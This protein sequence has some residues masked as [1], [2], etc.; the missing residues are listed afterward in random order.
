MI[1]LDDP[2]TYNPQLVKLLVSQGAQIRFIG[3]IRQSLEDVYLKLVKHT[4]E[5]GR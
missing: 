1:A 5:P 4:Q 2:E 3:E